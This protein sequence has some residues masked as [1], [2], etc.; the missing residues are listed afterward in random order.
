MHQ[1][2]VTVVQSAHSRHEADPRAIPPNAREPGAQQA[3]G[4]DDLGVGH[5]GGRLARQAKD[6]LQ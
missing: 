4:V 2:Q 6:A 5:G 3:D 1:R